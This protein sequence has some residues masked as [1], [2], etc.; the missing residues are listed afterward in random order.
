MYKRGSVNCK[1]RVEGRA[2]RKMRSKEIQALKGMSY[3]ASLVSSV[4]SPKK[5]NSATQGNDKLQSEN[6]I[7]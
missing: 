6:R 1:V 3:E 4:L 2:I 5:G 7:V